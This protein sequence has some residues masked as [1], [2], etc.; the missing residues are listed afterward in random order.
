MK[1]KIILPLLVILTILASCKNEVVQKPDNLIEKEKMVNIM[2]DLSVL[3]AI[4]IQNPS[5]LDTFKINSNE[6]IYKKYKIDSAQFAQSNIYY[7]SDYKEFKKM[8]EEIK[9]RLDKNKSL[10]ETLIKDKKKKAL[11]LEKAKKKAKLKK[12]ADS[13]KKVKQNLAKELDSI[14]KTKK[15]I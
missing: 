13:I 1:T 11:L 3:E 7:A 8:F 14:K 6:Y 4:K 5:S 10:T 2:Y 9:F 15:G 12:E